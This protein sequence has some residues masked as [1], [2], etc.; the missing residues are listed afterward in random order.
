M[1]L[2]QSERR[3]AGDSAPDAPP[4]R[5]KTAAENSRHHRATFG[6]R[7]KRS[8]IVGVVLAASEVLFDVVDCVC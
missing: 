7:Q 5:Q 2:R 6:G 1:H 8:N 3:A 4:D